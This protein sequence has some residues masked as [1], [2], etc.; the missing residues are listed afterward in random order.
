MM[1]SSELRTCGT[2]SRMR[3]V[4]VQDIRTA[5]LHGAALK[6]NLGQP[7]LIKIFASTHSA[8]KNARARNGIV[9][10]CYRVMSLLI[11]MRIP[12]TYLYVDV[13]QYHGVFG[14]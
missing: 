7:K 10:L 14:V 3:M 6:N 4:R 11:E 13:I 12:E 1:D 9:L 8:G 2:T 5:G